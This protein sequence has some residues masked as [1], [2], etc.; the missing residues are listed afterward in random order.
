MA[1]NHPGCRI[2]PRWGAPA[3]CRPARTLRVARFWPALAVAMLA[4]CSTAHATRV[5]PARLC[6]RLGTDDTLR[7]IPAGL[8]PQVNATFH[9]SLPASVAVAGTVFRCD[10]GLVK[11]CT[12]GANLVCGK[13]DPRRHNQGATAWCRTHPDAAAVPAFATGHATI[14]AWRCSGGTARIERQV[15]PVDG[16]GFITRNWRTLRP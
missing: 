1:S 10:Q 2:H 3:T 11:L 5:S 9:T 15:D 4:A 7:P 12:R 14:F 13:A 16:R 8:V 6:A